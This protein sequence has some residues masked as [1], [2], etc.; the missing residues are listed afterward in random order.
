MA[1]HSIPHQP[2]TRK[3]RKPDPSRVVQTY[4]HEVQSK[5]KRGALR[6][7]GDLYNISDESVRRYVAADE[8]RAQLAT[9]TPAELE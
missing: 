6:R 8:A 5:G 1:L 9:P 4:W 7:A 2:S 3:Q